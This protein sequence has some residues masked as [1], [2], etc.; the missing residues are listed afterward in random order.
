MSSMTPPTS[1]L[2]VISGDTILSTRRSPIALAASAAAG[3]AGRQHARRGSACRLRRGCALRRARRSAL[4]A[5]A[6]GFAAPPAPAAAACRAARRSA[7]RR[8]STGPRAMG[9]RTP[10]PRPPRS[11]AA[12][13]GWRSPTARNNG[14]DNAPPRVL[15]ALNSGSAIC[16][17]LAQVVKN[18]TIAGKFS[19]PNSRSNDLSRID[20]SFSACAV[21]STGLR[22]AANGTQLDHLFLR[23]LG[24]RRQFEPFLLGGVGHQHAGAARHRHHREAA[25]ARQPAAGAGIGDLDR[26]LPG[27]WRARPPSW[28]KRGVIDRVGCRRARRCARPPPRRRSSSRRPS[29]R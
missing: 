6:A 16:G 17:E 22:A 14:R 12:S 10:R 21:T 4:P 1:V 7:S 15:T 29:S 18:P 13:P 19:L 28:R 20:G 5:G 9:P 25:R 23:L 3:G 27:S 26:G 8:R 2:W 24:E 11:A